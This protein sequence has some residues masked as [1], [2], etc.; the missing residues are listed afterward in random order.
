MKL[1]FIMEVS[2][3][4]NGCA[5]P[6][7]LALGKVNLHFCQFEEFSSQRALKTKAY[8]CQSIESMK[9]WIDKGVG[10]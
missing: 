10:V 7:G 6:C 3:E 5:D 9:T 2:L 4:G 8:S 1:G